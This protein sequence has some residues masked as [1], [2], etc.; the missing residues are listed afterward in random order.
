MVDLD[1]NPSVYW[2]SSSSDFNSPSNWCLELDNDDNMVGFTDITNLYS[3][4]Y[5]TR[6]VKD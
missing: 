1:T 2:T 5:T 4:S 3:N 6:C